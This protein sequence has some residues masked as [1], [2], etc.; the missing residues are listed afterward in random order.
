MSLAPRLFCFSRHMFFF[1]PL[2]PLTSPST[3]DGGVGG[4]KCDDVCFFPLPKWPLPEYSEF[5]SS[6]SGIRAGLSLSLSLSLAWGGNKGGPIWVLN[7]DRLVINLLCV[8]REVGRKT[9]ATVVTGDAVT[10][11]AVADG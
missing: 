5:V 4:V 2:L 8:L 9:R 1:P 11:K 10:P 6:A 3:Q 7:T